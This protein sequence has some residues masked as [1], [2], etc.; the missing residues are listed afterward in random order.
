MDFDGFFIKQSKFNPIFNIEAICDEVAKK[1]KEIISE[2]ASPHELKIVPIAIS[3]S[4]NSH[5]FYLNIHI[6]ANKFKKI[7]NETIAED[8]IDQIQD[9][10]IDMI[11]GSSHIEEWQKTAPMMTD[12]ISLFV[13]GDLIFGSIPEQQVD[14]I[15][16][17]SQNEHFN[18]PKGTKLECTR[19]LHTIERYSSKYG[20]I[21]F[22]GTYK[23]ATIKLET[24]ID[25]SGTNETPIYD[26]DISD[27]SEL[28]EYSTELWEIQT[29]NKKIKKEFE[30]ALNNG[31][32]IFEFI[33]KY[34]FE[35]TGGQYDI[36]PILHFNYKVI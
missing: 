22:T 4:E 34:N 10:Y 11:R 21:T 3:I 23:S 33:D 15:D 29:T 16:N 9:L 6:S 26:I 31:D 35:N 36:V 30:S 12:D 14:G 13:N 7:I 28:S 32:D 8:L 1:S 2:Y 17:T 5:N 24:D 20:E 27:D 18:F 25:F 19:C